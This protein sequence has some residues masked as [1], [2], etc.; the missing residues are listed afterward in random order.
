MATTDA[1]LTQQ[2]AWEALET[3][4]QQI[5]DAHLRQLFDDDP[6]AASALPPKLW[7]STSTTRNT[8]PTTAPP[9]R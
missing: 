7:D 1:T 8:A 6:D 9:T 2:P 3:H 4:Y 5:K